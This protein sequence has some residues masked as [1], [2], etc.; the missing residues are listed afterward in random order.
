M[1]FTFNEERLAQYRAI[2]EAVAACG[3]TAVM[4]A[5]GCVRDMLLDKPI[6]DIDLFYE[7]ELNQ[8]LIKQRFAIK[9][10]KPP[11]SNWLKDP[12]GNDVIPVP[13]DDLFPYP[14]NENWNVRY[15]HVTFAGCDLPIQLIQVKD[16]STH[17]DTFGANISKVAYFGDGTMYLSPGFIEDITTQTLHIDPNCGEKYQDKIITKFPEFEAV[18]KCLMS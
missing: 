7:G 17:L 6:K 18:H 8:D 10:K 11:V 13:M 5:G 15:N 9:P 2:Q 12:M 16:V 1:N 3:A 14:E 4:V